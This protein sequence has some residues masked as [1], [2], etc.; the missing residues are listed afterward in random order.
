MYIVRFTKYLYFLL[1]RYSRWVLRHLLYI[2]KEMCYKFS[3]KAFHFKKWEKLN[4]LCKVNRVLYIYTYTTQKIT[5]IHEQ[6]SF[7]LWAFV[8]LFKCK[9]T[10]KKYWFKLYFICIRSTKV[11][12][13][14]SNIISMTYL[15]IRVLSNDLPI[16][17]QGSVK[18]K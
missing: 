5:H 8:I 17:P 1:N 6:S 10:V 7:I 9:Y 16:L 14:I 13:E 15:T 2:F 4:S 3:I 18:F 11:I 12:V